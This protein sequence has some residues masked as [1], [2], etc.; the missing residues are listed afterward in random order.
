MPVK[1]AEFIGGEG[2]PP[3]LPNIPIPGRLAALATLAAFFFM[4]A[5][6]LIPMFFTYVRPNEVGVKQVKISLFGQSGLQEKVIDVPG[7]AFRIPG[8]EVIHLFPKNRQ[9]LDFADEKLR[10]VPGK[11]YSENVARIQTSDGFFVDVDISVLYRIVDAFK[12]IQ[13]YGAGDGY[14]HRGI[15]PKAE[16]ILRQVLGELATEDFYNSPKR[17]ARARLASD[18]LNTEMTQFGIEV[19]H[20]LVRQFRYT[21]EIQK[22]IEEKKLQDQLAQK[23]DSE[24]KAAIEQA[25][26]KRITQEGEAAVRITIQEGLAYA[27]KKD[28]QKELYIRTKRAE[29]DLL[30]QL[31]EAKRTKLENEA[32]QARGVDRKVA[33][34]MA[35]VL[36]GLEVIIIPSGG[37]QGMNPLD[38]DEMIRLLGVDLS[39]ED[40]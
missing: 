19:E 20:V 31:A 7:F 18:L 39:G 40:R 27:V 24:A 9:V 21:A 11:Y 15:I 2:G 34:E 13:E 29:A 12:V 22:N 38:L 1:K 32:M 35:K 36:R 5:I 17:A 30:I 14:L 25:V 6:I 28:A 23:N 10:S 37:P 8:A 4:A 3:N 16:P 26:V 33:L